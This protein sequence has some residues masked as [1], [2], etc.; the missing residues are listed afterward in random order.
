MIVVRRPG[1]VRPAGTNRCG[2]S[3]PTYWHPPLAATLGY[4]T[5]SVP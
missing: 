3:G 5:D 4:G 1:V 2:V